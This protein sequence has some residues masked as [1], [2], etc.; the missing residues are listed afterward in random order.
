MIGV[1]NSALMTFAG[2]WFGLAVLFG[3]GFSVV[4][5]LGKRREQAMMRRRVIAT[6]YPGLGP[7]A[8]YQPTMA[9]AEDRGAES[10]GA[11]SLGAESLGAESLGAESL[12][13]GSRAAGNRGVAS[14]EPGGLETAAARSSM[15]LEC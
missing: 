9:E 8:A 13:A 2:G 5:T 7:Q 11:E 6:D 3:A 14:A 15:R 4:V 12:G 10:R 1:W